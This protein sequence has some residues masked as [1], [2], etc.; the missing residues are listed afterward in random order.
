MALYFK[1]VINFKG[2]VKMQAQ[3]LKLTVYV[4]G[5]SINIDPQTIWQAAQ[6][7][8]PQINKPI[9]GPPNF[10]ARIYGRIYVPARSFVVDL[11]DQ[12]K[13]IN[14]DLE[15][16]KDFTTYD[17]LAILGQLDIPVEHI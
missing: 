4:K 8:N 12:N 5:K 16:L 2:G 6:R 7:N 17:A 1:K 10:W 13:Q 3:T 9:S 14:P 11:L 15:I